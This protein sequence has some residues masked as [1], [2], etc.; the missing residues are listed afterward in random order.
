[1]SIQFKSASMSAK[2]TAAVKTGE[3]I[4]PFDYA[5]LPR[6]QAKLAK[7]AA[8]FIESRHKKMASSVIEIG[9]KLAEVKVSLG[10]GNF[11]GWVEAEF[12]MSMRT[13]QSYM[14]AATGVGAKSEIVSHLPVTTLLEVAKSPEPIRAKVLEKMA[15]A[16]APL[17]VDK[18]REVLHEARIEQKRAERDAKLSPAQKKREKEARRKDREEQEARNVKRRQDEAREERATVRLAELL[19]SRLGEDRDEVATL[20]EQTNVQGGPLAYRLTTGVYGRAFGF[21]D[22]PRSREEWEELVGLLEAGEN[23]HR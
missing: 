11:T 12:T 23:P 1:M 4:L 22:R 19:L 2:A 15:S 14:A 17:P 8:E 5:V 9:R 13:A 18:V 20:L 6:D 3:V 10:H 16:E 7:D 21:N